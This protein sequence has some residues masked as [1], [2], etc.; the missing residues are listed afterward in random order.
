MLPFRNWGESWA[1]KPFCSQHEHAVTRE[2]LSEKKNTSILISTPIRSLI[3]ND[4]MFSVET[5]EILVPNS[6]KRWCLKQ[7]NYFSL[8][9]YSHLRWE[10]E[11]LTSLAQYV[12]I[13]FFKTIIFNKFKEKNLE[14]MFNPQQH[15]DEWKKFWFCVPFWNIKISHFWQMKY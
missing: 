3:D 13:C 6:P 10:R 8:R 14:K 2:T 11:G 1:K 4:S 12:S 5:E 9:S 7:C 15:A